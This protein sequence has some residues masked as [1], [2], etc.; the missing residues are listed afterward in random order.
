MASQVGGARDNPLMEEPAAGAETG[1]A[2]LFGLALVA[3]AAGLGGAPVPAAACAGAEG[4]SR[5]WVGNFTFVRRA[6]PAGV[7]A[8]AL[9]QVPIGIEGSEGPGIVHVRALAD[10]RTLYSV[11]GRTRSSRFG[12]QLD[13]GPWSDSDPAKGDVI[14]VGAPAAMGGRGLVRLLA[15]A[16]GSDLLALEEP[17]GLHAFARGVRL[18]GDL[19]GDGRPD[20]AVGASVTKDGEPLGPGT[21]V[22]FS[23][24]TGKELWRSS[25]EA[26]IEHCFDDISRIGDVDRDGADDLLVGVE[27]ALSSTRFDHTREAGEPIVI[28][29]ALSSKSGKTLWDLK[30]ARWRTMGTVRVSAC[31]DVDGDGCA[32]ALVVHPVG[33]ATVPDRFRVSVVSGKTGTVLSNLDRVPPEGWWIPD[34]VEMGDVNGDGVADL[35]V[36]LREIEAKDAGEPDSL[37]ELLCGKTHARLRAVGGEKPRHGVGWGVVPC[38]DVTGDSVPDLLVGGAMPLSRLKVLLVSGK[39]GA[40]VRAYEE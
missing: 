18:V 26:G 13:S 36:E 30:G 39:D 3:V 35:A 7:P 8:I 15:G 14:A 25:P 37:V 12:E 16:D 34:A 22:L 21:V 20:L 5:G 24:G 19:D 31:R 11:R 28:A 4:G 40:V 33:D 9:S 38:G 1:A 17:K 32:D 6:G 23:T 29:R 10:G 2:R 27:G